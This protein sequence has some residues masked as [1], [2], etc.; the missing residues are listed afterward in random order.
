VA[1]AFLREYLTV[2]GD[3]A[4]RVER[5]RRFTA[6]GVELHQ[7]VFVPAGVAQYVDQVAVSAVRPVDAGTEV[8]MLVHLLQMRLGTYRDG[9]PSPS[10]SR[11]PLVRKGPRSAGHRVRR[12]CRSTL[13]WRPNGPERPPPQSWFRPRSARP[14]R[15]W[16]PWSEPTPTPSPASAA[17]DRP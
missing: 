5:L 9:G 11:W 16:S 2:G 17:T 4:A 12:R 13:D 1:A 14:G 7:S 6:S 8:T 15:R 3:R 10:S